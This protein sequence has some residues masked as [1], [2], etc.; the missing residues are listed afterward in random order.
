MIKKLNKVKLYKII[1]MSFNKKNYLT[2][3]S[4]NKKYNNK[5]KILKKN[6]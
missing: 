4:K 5:I 2:N 3:K 6:K 1:K